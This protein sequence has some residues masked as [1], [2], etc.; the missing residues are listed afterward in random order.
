MC[1]VKEISPFVTLL[2]QEQKTTDKWNIKLT[3]LN[4]TQSTE[5]EMAL[6]RLAKLKYDLIIGVGFLFKEPMNR[7]AVDFPNVN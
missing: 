1:A 4:P 5:P 6:R 7:V 2:I 3:E